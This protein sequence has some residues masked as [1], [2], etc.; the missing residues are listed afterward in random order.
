MRADEVKWFKKAKESLNSTLKS[1]LTPEKMALT[2]ALGVSLGILPLPWGATL[3][4]ALIAYVFKLNQAGIQVVNY[5]VY[6][7]QIALFVPFYRVGE[8]LFPETLPAMSTG[9]NGKIL[10]FLSHLGQSTL[11]AIFAWVMLAPPLALI[12]Y[13]ILLTVFKRHR[14]FSSLTN[15]QSPNQP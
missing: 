10:N 8:K 2:V 6:P 1:C 9:G 13:L 3:L 11:K 14:R 5:M 4:C 7:L 15:Q 12:L